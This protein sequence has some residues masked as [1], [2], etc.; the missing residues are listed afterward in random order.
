MPSTARRAT[1]LTL[2]RFTAGYAQTP[3]FLSPAL[4][5][6][7][8]GVTAFLYALAGFGG[9]STYTA[10]LVLQGVDH[11]LI[12]VITL[13]CNLVVVAGGVLHHVRAGNFSWRAVLPFIATSMPM[14]ALGGSLAVSMETFQ[15]VMGIALLVSGLL[16][17]APA[18]HAGAQSMQGWRRWAFGLPLGAAIGLLSGITGIGGGIFLAPVLHLVGWAE[19]RSIAALTS[20]FILVNSLAGLAGHL[21]KW[22]LSGL[23]AELGMLMWLPLVVLIG[24]QVGSRIGAGPLGERVVR[25][26]T[27]VLVI[28]V[29]V[30][31]L[32]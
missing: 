12:P 1:G 32:L 16:L 18:P 19:G 10:L 7:A 11:R 20:G 28:A 4:L 13:V 6:V 8:F 26:L 2:P 22:E 25:R 30:R 23:Q 27:A 5:F 31:L 15:L 3:L 14:A 17:L 29:G 24:G 21:G 9:G